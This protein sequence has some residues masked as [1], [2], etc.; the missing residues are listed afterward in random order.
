MTPNLPMILQRSSLLNVAT[1]AFMRSLGA[2]LWFR[3]I[4]ILVCSGLDLT[5]EKPFNIHLN[6]S[7]PS[8]F[9][10]AIVINF[11]SVYISS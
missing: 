5:I 7:L 8:R 10:Y 1:I 2:S 9:V 6:I 3:R 4:E 11:I